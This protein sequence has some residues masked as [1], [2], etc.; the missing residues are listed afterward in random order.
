MPRGAKK[1]DLSTAM[2]N[3]LDPKSFVSKDGR[4][5]LAGEDMSVRRHY[6]WERCE[7][8]CEAPGCNRNISEETMHC[9]HMKPRS[10]GG[11]ENLN[12]LQALC[13]RC[14]KRKHPEKQLRWGETLADA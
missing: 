10:R 6:V 7:G 2:R 5:F 8:F 14:H 13:S 12:N 11:A 1:D 3:F 9:H 4:E